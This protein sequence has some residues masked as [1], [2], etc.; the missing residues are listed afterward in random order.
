MYTTK[1]AAMDEAL[2]SS[3]NEFRSKS[4]IS[5]RTRWS[6][7]PSC[8]A[9]VGEFQLF[10]RFGLVQ[11]RWVPPLF[12]PVVFGLST[13]SAQW[14]PSMSKNRCLFLS[15]LICVE[16]PRRADLRSPSQLLHWSADE[17]NEITPRLNLQ[18]SSLTHRTTVHIHTCSV[19]VS[20]SLFMC[21]PS[22]ATSNPTSPPFTQINRP[23]SKHNELLMIH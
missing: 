2:E 6:L 14:S 13:L 7:L 19:F 16:S 4:N 15:S 9:P 3:A 21:A 12:S 17:R 22:L 10:S 5:T 20:H 8:W 11:M 23:T 1:M 18:P